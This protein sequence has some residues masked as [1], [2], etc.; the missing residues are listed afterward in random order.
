MS[1]ERKLQE[2]LD[3]IAMEELTIRAA[4][5][6]CLFRSATAQEKCGASQTLKAADATSEE[7]RD[8]NAQQLEYLAVEAGAWRR[9][10]LK[11]GIRVLMLSR[12]LAFSL[13]KFKTRVVCAL[14][15]RRKY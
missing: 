2:V 8:T 4:H 5:Q 6:G 9:H 14:C 3:Y 11:F 12:E 10:G 1:K 7:A 13:E 15:N